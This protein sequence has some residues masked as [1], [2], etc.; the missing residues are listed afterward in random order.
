MEIKKVNL[1]RKPI[2][3]EYIQSKQ[4]FQHVVNAFS[5]TKIPVWKQ[6]L[7]YGAIGVAS[8]AAVVTSTVIHFN[9]T[10]IDGKTITL[11]STKKED[12]SEHKTTVQYASVESSPK[13][14]EKSSSEAKVNSIENQLVSIESN[15][16]ERPIS[17][18]SL[19]S[20][21]SIEDESFSTILPNISGVYQGDISYDKLCSSN[22]IEVK[23][24]VVVKSF[25][26]QYATGFSDKEVVINDKK[27]TEV[28]C[29]DLEKSGFNQMVFITEIEAFDG[30]RKITLPSMNFWVKFDS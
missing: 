27:L 28:V 13:S 19:S 3:S 9:N 17:K 22:G 10:E 7:F 15:E 14:I 23:K 16:F 1:D 30:E 26:I 25:K 18:A 6:P 12:K 4:D 29:K 20:Q 8:L 2:T 21:K 24:G 11:S 5:K